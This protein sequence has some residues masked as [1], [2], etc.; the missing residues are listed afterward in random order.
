MTTIQI[1]KQE[2][3][4]KD[5]KKAYKEKYNVSL[6]YARMI[7]ILIEKAK[8]DDFRTA[9]TAKLRVRKLFKNGRESKKDGK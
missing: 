9:E 4:L 2:Q 8:V 7:G 3:Q 1:I 6:T 5:L